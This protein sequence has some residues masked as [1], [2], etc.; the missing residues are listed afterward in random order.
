VVAKDN[1]SAYVVKETN[2]YEEWN[3]THKNR[4]RLA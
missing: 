1:A 3:N 2:I 4:C